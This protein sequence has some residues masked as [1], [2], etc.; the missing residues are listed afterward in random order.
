[1]TETERSDRQ[2]FEALVRRH[3]AQVCAV[4]YA[5]LRDRARS[6]EVAQDA[7]LIAWRDRATV[8]PSARWICGIARNLARN[9]TRRRR[10]APMTDDP[11][12]PARDPRDELI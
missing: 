9:A 11:A 8:M 12:T 3:Q 2:E 6:E 7:F 1:M 10:E 4:A 5:V